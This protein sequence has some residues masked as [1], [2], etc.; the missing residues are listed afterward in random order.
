MIGTRRGLAEACY[1]LER[2]SGVQMGS[3][4]EAIELGIAIFML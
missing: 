4:L 2:C 1:I 3:E